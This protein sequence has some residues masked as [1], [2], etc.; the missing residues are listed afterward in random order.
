MKNKNFYATR[1]FVHEITMW[2][3]LIF[4]LFILNSSKVFGQ[5]NC[6]KEVVTTVSLS[7]SEG[8]ESHQTFQ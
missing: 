7:S 1:R 6:Y 2:T 8:F 3:L 5:G 4:S